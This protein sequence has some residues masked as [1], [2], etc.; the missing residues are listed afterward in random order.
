M[1]FIVVVDLS[2]NQSM[3]HSICSGWVG[4]EEEEYD[5]WIGDMHFGWRVKVM[6]G[7]H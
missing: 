6:Q 2:V 7:Q 1:L 5:F 3:N 4:E